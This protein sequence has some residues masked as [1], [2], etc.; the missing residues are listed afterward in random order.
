MARNHKKYVVSYCSGATGYGWEAEHDRL[1][2][3]ESFID[4]MRH[5]YTARVTVWDSTLKEFI[6]Y[7]RALSS[8]PETD[9]LRSFERDMRT[10]TR[11]RK[12]ETK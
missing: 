4:E 9:M 12:E 1:D 6:F 11:K 10:T 7:K 5:E 8:N 2:E 3:F